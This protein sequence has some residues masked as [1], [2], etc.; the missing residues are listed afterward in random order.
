M[1]RRCITSL[2]ERITTLISLFIR[3]SF[4]WT[5]KS[6]LSTVLPL[7]LFSYN[8]ISSERIIC[9]LLYFIFIETACMYTTFSRWLYRRVG[10]GSIGQGVWKSS[11]AKWTKEAAKHAHLP[12]RPNNAN[13]METDQWRKPYCAK[14]HVKNCS[15]TTNTTQIIWEE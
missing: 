1:T 5:I 6:W 9:Q 8:A 3:P 2:W 11:K 10:L 14:G 4:N 15:E 7:L 12:T 13:Q